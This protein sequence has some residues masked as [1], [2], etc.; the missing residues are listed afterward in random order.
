M[1]DRK[2]PL[3]MDG[4]GR[5]VDNVF[6]ERLWCSVKYQE[7]YL[8]AYDCFA[9][10]RA[11]LGRYVDFC[12]TEKRHQS[13]ADARPTTCTANLLPGW[14]R[15]PRMHLSRCLI[16]GVHFWRPAYP[17]GQH[18]GTDQG[19]S[20]GSDEGWIDE[21]GLQH[22]TVGVLTHALIYLGR[23]LS[24]WKP[25]RDSWP[26]RIRRAIRDVCTG[27]RL[28]AW[29]YWA[30][31]TQNAP[32]TASQLMNRGALNTAHD[33][34]LS[35]FNNSRRDADS[36]YVVRQVSCD[37][38]PS[39]NNDVITDTTFGNYC[40]VSTNVAVSPDFHTPS[41]FDARRY[42]CVRANMN[43]MRD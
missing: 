34:R 2:Y 20:A 4:K 9:N 29:G 19:Q 3:S 27:K 40:G 13:L 22:A 8:R 38:C 25:A 24:G 42:V 39:P 36:R 15:D 37:H 33:L 28:F 35:G 7:L 32:I 31:A 17:P 14:R 11:S 6:V 1:V 5:W 43:M 26:S 12:N 21:P 41:K 23:G 30:A 16:V 10:A 18:P